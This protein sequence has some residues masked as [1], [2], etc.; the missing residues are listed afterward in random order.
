MDLTLPAAAAAASAATPAT[1]ALNAWRSA[2]PVL[3]MALLMIVALLAAEALARWLK[4]PRTIGPMLAGVLASP[5]ALDLI[6]RTELDP[7]KPLLDLAVGVLVFELGTR[8]QPRWLM[9]NPWLALQSLLESAL[10]FIA[11][12]WALTALGASPWSAAMAGAV[13]MAS[14][15]VITMCVLHECQPRGQATDRLL[16]LSAINSVLAVL[17]LKGWGIA[18]SMGGAA[19]GQD[20]FGIL[21]NAVFVLCGSFLLGVGAGLL[22]E[23]VS[24]V[25]RLGQNVAVLHMAVVVLA[26]MLAQPWKLSSLLTLLVAGIFARWRMGHRLSVE[27]QL[28]SA[29]VALSTLL[30]ISLGVLSTLQGSLQ[31][32]PWVLAIIGARWLAKTLAIV[33]LARPSSLGWR[34]SLG[35]GLALQPMSSIAVLL[36]ADTFGWPASLP[37]PEAAV[38][39]ALLIATTL[40]QL[41]GPLWIQLGLGRVA[42]EQLRKT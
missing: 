11:V 24:R 2:D 28:G 27:P 3:G 5:V 14:S 42:D 6:Q 8:L 22:I 19:P 9:A 21:G 17:A 18:A 36:T 15:P 30:L 31:L 34:Q 25:A 38:L 20:A 13:A 16:L 33:A 29:G 7:W 35:L 39:Q 4:L 12:T 23:G 41:S 10:T 37:T 40:M 26:A 32:W 1:L